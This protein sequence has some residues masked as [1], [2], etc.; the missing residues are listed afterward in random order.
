MVHFTMYSIHGTIYNVHY[1]WYT[2]Q[3]TVYSIQC[4]LYTIQCTLYTLQCTLNYQT[5]R[6]L[7]SLLLECVHLISVLR[8]NTDTITQ[9][10]VNIASKGRMTTV[11]KAMKGRMVYSKYSNPSMA[12]QSLPDAPS[13]GGGG[14]T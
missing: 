13:V 9:L 5:W 6:N 11:T 10:L 12:R 1:T 14:V 2:I 4:T 7:F 8:V 3:C